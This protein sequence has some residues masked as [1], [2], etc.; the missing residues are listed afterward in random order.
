M[1]TLL[2]L[3]TTALLLV[4]AASSQAAA[5]DLWAII[6]A[7]LRPAINPQPLPPHTPEPERAIAINPQP[8]PP[9]Q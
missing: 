1:K 6:T 7:V 5:P 2:R 4:S 8:L 3:A 9:R